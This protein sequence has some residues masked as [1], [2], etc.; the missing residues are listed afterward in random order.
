MSL[1]VRSLEVRSGSVS[2][3]EAAIQEIRASGD[4]GVDR[5]RRSLVPLFSAPGRNSNFTLSTLLA[6]IELENLEVRR[7]N[8][9]MWKVSALADGVQ[10]LRILLEN[11]KTGAASRA[12]RSSGLWSQ[13]RRAADVVATLI[14]RSGAAFASLFFQ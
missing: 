6:R 10:P 5:L 8:D 1:L 7:T 9:A 13:G 12:G 4:A 11:L 3:P 14:T 2:G